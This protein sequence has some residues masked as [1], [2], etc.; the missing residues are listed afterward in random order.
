M[1]SFSNLDDTKVME[2]S[3]HETL[4]NP[5]EV[6]SDSMLTHTLK[7]KESLNEKIKKIQSFLI[8]FENQFHD[9]NQDF[10]MQLV[11]NDISHLK[12]LEYDFN[13]AIKVEL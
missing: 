12:N 5:S 6:T 1:Q 8:S 11:V 13:N 2:S 10:F 4:H 9:K 3:K 7:I